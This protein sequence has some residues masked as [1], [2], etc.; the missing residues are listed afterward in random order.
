MCLYIY[1]VFC[2]YFLIFEILLCITSSVSGC[3]NLD[4]QFPR[5][6]GRCLT[7]IFHL[8]FHKLQAVDHPYLVVYSKAA[9]VAPPLQNGSMTD[10]DSYEQTCGLC[11]EPAE[12]PVVSYHFGY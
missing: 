3:Q 6:F 8:L 2:L 9:N 11:H 1:S 7:N 4:I 12:D 5:S 10:A